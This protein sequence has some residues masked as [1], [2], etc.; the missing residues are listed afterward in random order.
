MSSSIACASR[1]WPRRRLE[2]R[3]KLL[4][5]GDFTGGPIS[6]TIPASGGRQKSLAVTIDLSSEKNFTVGYKASVAPGANFGRIDTASMGR[7]GSKPKFRRISRRQASQLPRRCD[8]PAAW[9]PYKA[10][11][12]FYWAG[13]TFGP[14]RSLHVQSRSLH[15]GVEPS[16]HNVGASGLAAPGPSACEMLLP[17]AHPDARHAATSKPMTILTI[18]P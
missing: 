5:I 3:H 1:G 13:V 12:V 18:P 15:G 7:T 2:S 10:H 9:V 17:A 8:I 6:A 16:R 4:T 14:P 11:A